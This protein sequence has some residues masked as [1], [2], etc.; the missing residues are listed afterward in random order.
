MNVNTKLPELKNQIGF[1]FKA[2]KQK[3]KQK[4]TNTGKNQTK[5]NLAYFQ[6]HFKKFFVKRRIFSNKNKPYL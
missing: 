2:K 4:S 6:F 1:L 3:L 5:I